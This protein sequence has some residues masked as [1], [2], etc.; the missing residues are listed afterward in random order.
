M[1]SRQAQQ[2]PVMNP[3]SCLLKQPSRRRFLPSLDEELEGRYLHYSNE[4]GAWIRSG[5]AVGSDMLC[6]TNGIVFRN[7][8]GHLKKVATVS[9]VDGDFFNTI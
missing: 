3:N 2:F 8:M 7:K 5:K 1:F 6:P 4:E 9:L